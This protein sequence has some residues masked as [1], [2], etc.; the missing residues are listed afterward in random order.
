MPLQHSP[1]G[2]A[3]KL[4]AD[5]LE[6]EPPKDGAL[7]SKEEIA[8]MCGKER[9]WLTRCQHLIK[10]EDLDLIDYEEDTVGYAPRCFGCCEGNHCGKGG[11]VCCRGQEACCHSPCGPSRQRISSAPATGD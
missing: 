10:G 2:S 3:A 5:E 6:P 1:K 7:Y 9:Q 8:E 4:P 11:G